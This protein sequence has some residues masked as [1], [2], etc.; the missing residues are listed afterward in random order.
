MS[1]SKKSYPPEMVLAN[2]RAM[3]EALPYMTEHELLVAI[4]EEAARPT[5]DKRRDVITRLYGRYNSI[6]RERELQEYMA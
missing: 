1:K 4:K 6:R 5:E 2:W 3:M